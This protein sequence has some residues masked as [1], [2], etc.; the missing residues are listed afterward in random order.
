MDKLKIHF[1]IIVEGKYDKIKI[2]S[3]ADATVITTDGFGVFKSHEKLSLIRALAQKSK[4]IVMTD[5][6]GAGKL[7]R[8]HITSAIPKDRIIPLYTPQIKGRERRKDH[9]SAEGYLGVEGT[10]SQVLRNLLSPYADTSNAYSDS[11]KISKADFF[12][13]GLSGNSDSSKKRNILAEKFSLPK[14]MTANALIS[15]L[16]ALITYEE[17]EKVISGSDFNSGSD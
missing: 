3:I 9:S 1:P 11:R 14:D 10:D 17:F 2:D 7:I 6:D 15:A 13:Y 8:S 12:N 5:S 4:I 16:N